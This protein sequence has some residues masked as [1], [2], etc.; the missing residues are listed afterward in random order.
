MCDRNIDYLV[1]DGAYSEMGADKT[2]ITPIE[3]RIN[4]PQTKSLS[5]MQIELFLSH[6]IC[7]QSQRQKGI[8]DH[9]VYLAKIVV[10][11][12]FANEKVNAD[13]SHSLNATLVSVFPERA[14]PLLLQYLHGDG[15]YGFEQNPLVKFFKLLTY[16]CAID[17]MLLYIISNPI[18]K[19][20]K[21]Y[22]KDNSRN[23]AL[24]LR[25]C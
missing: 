3:Q 9:L 11:E 8:N 22:T 10:N 5:K 19:Y 7:A 21:A 12:Q 15:L 13:V 17:V 20:K 18:R 1:C 23:S 14:K 6:D 2:F 4:T 24:K 25:A 16:D